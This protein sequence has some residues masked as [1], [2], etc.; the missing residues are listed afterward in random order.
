LVRFDGLPIQDENSYMADI[1]VYVLFIN[2][3]LK[4]ANIKAS[5]A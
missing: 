1:A 3:I 2:D 4:L 5:G